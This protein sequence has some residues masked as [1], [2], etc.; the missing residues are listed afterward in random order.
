MIGLYLLWVKT[1]D[2]ANRD[3]QVLGLPYS[4]WNLVIV[5]PFVVCLLC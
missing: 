3:C 1:T 2:W 5:L 4:V